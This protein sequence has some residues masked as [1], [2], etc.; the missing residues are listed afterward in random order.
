M[1][2]FLSSSSISTSMACDCSRRNELDGLD[3]IGVHQVT[4][5]QH[6]HPST[7]FPPHE[8]FPATVVNSAEFGLLRI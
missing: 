7:K 6:L 1:T 8:L 4:V 3:L 2:P 5:C